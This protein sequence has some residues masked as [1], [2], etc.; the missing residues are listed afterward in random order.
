[1]F[2]EDRVG[3][4]STKNDTSQWSPNLNSISLAASLNLMAIEVR[5]GTDACYKSIP[6]TQDGD[7][8]SISNPCVSIASDVMIGLLEV[9]RMIQV[10]KMDHEWQISGEVEARF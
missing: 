10:S 2:P 7:V 9:S 3:I 4:R 6:R 8:K 5:V 1:M